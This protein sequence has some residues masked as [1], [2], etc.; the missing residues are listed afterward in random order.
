MSNKLVLDFSNLSN[1]TLR[2]LAEDTNSPATVLS[3]LSSSYDPAIRESVACNHH[4]PQ[5][6]LAKLSADKDINIR[7]C[8]VFNP[9]VAVCTVTPPLYIAK[10]STT[11][12]STWQ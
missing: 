6:V 3:F 5:N 4:T 12:V 11:R 7:Y 2:T 1:D 9:R 8:V 10:H